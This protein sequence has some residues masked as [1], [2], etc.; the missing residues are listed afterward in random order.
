MT[1][2]QAIKF[3]EE[4][5]NYFD[6]KVL[7]TKEDSSYWAYVTNAS[8]CRQIADL[9]KSIEDDKK[10]LKYRLSMMKKIRNE[11]L[12]E[13]LMDCMEENQKLKETQ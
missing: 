1:P 2:E 11:K 4:A 10:K 9:I 13:K 8:G 12:F 6:K 5:A 3:L 7:A